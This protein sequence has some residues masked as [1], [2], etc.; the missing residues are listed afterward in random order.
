ME[1][2]LQRLGAGFHPQALF[3][4]DRLLRE[5]GR[6]ENLAH[7]SRVISEGALDQRASVLHML[8]VEQRFDRMLGYPAQ[9][10]PIFEEITVPLARF[11]AAPGPGGC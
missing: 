7:Q 4:M 2:V 8:Q 1:Q 6:A 10:R 11:R 9:L 3:D 5:Y